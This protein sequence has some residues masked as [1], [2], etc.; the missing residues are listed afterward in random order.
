MDLFCVS[1]L[2][3]FASFSLSLSCHCGPMNNISTMF[4]LK[5]LAMVLW[6]Y[7]DF[8]RLHYNDKCSRTWVHVFSV[9][10]L[11]TIA[12]LSHTQTTLAY[13]SR[14]AHTKLL[15]SDDDKE[16]IHMHTNTRLNQQ[17][18]QWT[19]CSIKY[20]FFL[21]FHSLYVF[22]SCFHMVLIFCNTWWWWWSTRQAHAH[23]EKILL[24][25][26][27]EITYGCRNNRQNVHTLCQIEKSTTN[28]NQSIQNMEREPRDRE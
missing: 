23:T 9:K 25:V 1:S 14:L 15:H 22:V 24:N 13:F 12:T 3:L 2:I 10:L 18:K 11:F 20:F 16:L 7:S 4:G 5:I 27:I 8:K 19:I 17:Q 26:W 21:V 6:Y 28:K